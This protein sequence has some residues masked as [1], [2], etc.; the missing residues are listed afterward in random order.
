MLTDD[1]HL[2]GISPIPTGEW[3]RQH[4]RN[5]TDAGDG[6][7]AGVYY[8]P[9]DGDPL[10]TAA[11]RSMLRG[12]GANCLRLAARSPNLNACAERFVLSI[13]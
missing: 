11:F 7:L 8:P 12:G 1:L 3:M 2:A 6:F 5:L 9:R 4:A 13:A 10:F